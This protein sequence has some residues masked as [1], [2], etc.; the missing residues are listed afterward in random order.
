MKIPPRKRP[1]MARPA[2]WAALPRGRLNLLILQA[3]PE[4]AHAQEGK[5]EGKDP[6]LKPRQWARPAPPKRYLVFNIEGVSSLAC[7]AKFFSN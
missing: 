3:G 2:L 5:E 7:C 1:K 6:A 4:P